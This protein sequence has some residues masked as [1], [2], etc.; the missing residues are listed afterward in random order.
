MRLEIRLSGAGGHGLVT[1]S[2]ILAEAASVGGFNVAQTQTYGPEARGGSAFADV[3][4]SDSPIYYPRSMKPGL[5]LALTQAS[6]DLFA[7]LADPEGTIVT[8]ADEVRAR[9]AGRVLEVPLLRMV[10]EEFGLETFAG[11]AGLGALNAIGEVASREAFETA[12][13]GRV[14]PK[15]AEVNVRVYRRGWELGKGALG[16]P[17]AQVFEADL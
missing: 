2:I 13:K 7:P 12:I 6:S 10:R 16:A 5:V 8:D 17:A 14:P 15:S 9:P 4:V 3:V 1:A 11:I